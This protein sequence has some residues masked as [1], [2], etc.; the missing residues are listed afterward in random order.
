VAD[1][2]R[3][4]GDGSFEAAYRV[5][6]M[7]VWSRQELMDQLQPMARAGAG[8]FRRVGGRLGYV[9]GKYYAP[10]AT[11]TEAM[12]GRPITVTPKANFRDVPKAL[13]PIYPD[14]DQSYEDGDLPVVP[15]EGRGW[16]PG[17]DEAEEFVVSMCPY[18]PQVQ[19]IA[20]I[21]ACFADMGLGGTDDIGGDVPTGCD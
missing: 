16:T 20:R 8:Q 6:G 7:I 3:E 5:G 12:Q 21:E 10:S 9:S 18:W 4:R 19:R 13:R 15:V 11:L 14:P 2:L 1:E 17:Q